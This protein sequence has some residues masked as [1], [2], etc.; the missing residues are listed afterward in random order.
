[1]YSSQCF[2]G[3]DWV[4]GRQ[5][6]TKLSRKF[7]SGFMK[8]ENRDLLIQVHLAIKTRRRGDG[9]LHVC[10]V[11]QHSVTCLLTG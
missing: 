5:Y 9:D 6:S 2:Y 10:E 4:I 8:E 1:M 3:V 7:F 11:Y